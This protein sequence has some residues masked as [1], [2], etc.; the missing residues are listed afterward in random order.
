[1]NF[2]SCNSASSSSLSRLVALS[3]RKRKTG[4]TT[5]QSNSHDTLMAQLLAILH[6]FS[7]SHEINQQQSRWLMCGDFYLLLS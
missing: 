4:H 1:M 2:I 7:L 3:R 5:Y 6:D